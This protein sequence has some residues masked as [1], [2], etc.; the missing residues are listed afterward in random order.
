MPVTA[1]ADI[2]I[3]GGLG[4]ANSARARGITILGRRGA[5]TLA[6]GRYRCQFPFRAKIRASPYE[7]RA[8]LL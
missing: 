3:S 2:A 6:E 7:R 5:A 4:A 1:A 8:D